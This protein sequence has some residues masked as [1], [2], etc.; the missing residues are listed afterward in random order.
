MDTVKAMPGVDPDRIA[1]A[2]YCFGGTGVL[3]YALLGMNDVA[4]VVSIHG[5]LAFNPP[6]GPTVGPKLLILSGGDDD[7][8]SDIM[9]LEIAF[10]TANATWEITR[11]SGIEHAFSVFSDNRYNAFADMRSSESMYHFLQETF[12]EI[13]FV[14][15]EPAEI[16]VTA[17]PYEDTDGTMLQGYLAMPDE[18]WKRPLPAVVIFPDWDG[19]NDYEK[20]RATMLADM[21]Y[22][23]FA[24]DIV[25]TANCNSYAKIHIHSVFSLSFS[26]DIDITVRS[27]SSRRLGHERAY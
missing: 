12:D 4:A 27:H 5:G 20:K 22:V 2:G 8:S 15:N 11:Y 9:D 19:V 6:A 10:D 17:V 25:S 1:L 18:T 13:D 26:P 23:A 24:A 3:M 14:S 7:A 16:R 21:G